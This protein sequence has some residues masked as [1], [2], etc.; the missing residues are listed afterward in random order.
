MHAWNSSPRTPRSNLIDEN[1]VLAWHSYYADPRLVSVDPASTGGVDGASRDVEVS[2]QNVR[3]CPDPRRFAVVARGVRS[4]IRSALC[5]LLGPDLEKQADRCLELCEG[6]VETLHVLLTQ[7]GCEVTSA[8]ARDIELL[9]AALTTRHGKPAYCLDPHARARK[10]DRSCLLDGDLRWRVGSQ[11][12][13]SVLTRRG[14][15]K[16]QPTSLAHWQD[17]EN[18]GTPGR[19]RPGPPGSMPDVFGVGGVGG[20]VLATTW[21]SMCHVPRSSRTSVASVQPDR[22]LT[23]ARQHRA[24]TSPGAPP[25]NGANRAMSVREAMSARGAGAR[26]ASRPCEFV[27]A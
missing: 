11:P 14:A 26:V 4:G 1:R 23:A 9:H 10:S 6:S 15:E 7:A 17:D 19:V 18:K 13:P 24:C 12:F 16:M 27:L 5:V 21:P 2:S 22:S 20:S 3:C 25:W 8:D